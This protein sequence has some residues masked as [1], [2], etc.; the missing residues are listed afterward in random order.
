MIT[1]NALRGRSGD[2]T[3][4]IV[5]FRPLYCHRSSNKVVSCIG[6]ERDTEIGIL[7]KVDLIRVVVLR[8]PNGFF[9]HDYFSAGIHFL[10]LR[11]CRLTIELKFK[12]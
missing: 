3:S 5:F 10:P 11:S 9:M 6:N 4:R 12:A 2:R 1:V 7:A 8:F